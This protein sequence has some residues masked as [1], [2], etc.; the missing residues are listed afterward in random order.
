MCSIHQ[1]SENVEKIIIIMAYVENVHLLRVAK[2]PSLDMF[3]ISLISF[4]YS[5]ICK[6]T[7][8]AH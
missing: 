2:Y 6:Q 8:I 1:V 5:L 4:S 3:L 7:Y